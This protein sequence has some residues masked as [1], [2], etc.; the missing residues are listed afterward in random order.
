M[1][2]L[3]SLYRGRGWRGHALIAVVVGLAAVSACGSNPAS[4]SANGNLR[5]MLTDAPLDDVD[6]VNI[7][8]TSVT[9]KPLGKPVEELT[10]TLPEN[11]IDLL[12]LTDNTVNF[13]TGAVDPGEY[14]FLHINID[15]R[16]SNIVENGVEKP[17]QVPSDEIK[18][19]GG[20]VVEDDHTTT[21]TLDFDAEK[22]LLRLG[23]GDWL[24]IPVIVTTGNNTSSD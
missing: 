3:L 2:L 9:A 4:P 19:L 10:L 5:L 23:S 18:I 13:A 1:P 11:P 24:L 14:E 6:E 12:T 17:L 8:F 16:R 15:P 21:L 7:Y 20:F 22:S